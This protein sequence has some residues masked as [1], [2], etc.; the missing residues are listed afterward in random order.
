MK[1][2]SPLDSCAEVS[3]LADA[4]A[5]EFFC[6]VLEE[7]WYEPYPVISI[8][9]RPA[10]KGHFRRFVDLGEA[11]KRAHDRGIPVFFT[12]SEHYYIQDQYDL[13]AWY[14]DGAVTA[15]VDGLIVTDFGLVTFVQERGYPVALHMSTGGTAFNRRSLR[16]FADMGIANVTL[17]RHLELEEMR[18]L[19]AGDLPVPI[20]AF[21]LNSRCINVDGFCTFQHGLAGREIMPMYRNACMLPF[22]VTLD[23]APP[24]QSPAD[25]VRHQQYV[26]RQKIWQHVHV[27]DHPCGACA[28]HDFQQMGIGS[29]KI[30]GRGNPIERKVRDVTFLA[31]LTNFLAADAPVRA[32]F[33]S[34]ARTLYQQTYDRPCRRHMCYYPSVLDN[35]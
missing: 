27:D 28:L 11:V 9:R 26:E 5:G 29:V 7:R 24:P 33:Y 22:E 19:L 6:G 15:G 21:V 10:G 20:T 18:G 13:I 12:L 25:T 23:G 2:L 3:L 32:A 14:L 4:G 16:F 8:N 34:R 17:P 31:S 35:V 1:I 30:V